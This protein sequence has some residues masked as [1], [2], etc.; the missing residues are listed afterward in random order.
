LD[1]E[2]KDQDIIINT[3][4]V[5]I[6][7]F[8]SGIYAK[9][10]TSEQISELRAR[11]GNLLPNLSLGSG[12]GEDAKQIMSGLELIRK[13]FESVANGSENDVRL[14]LAEDYAGLFL[15]VRGKVPH[16][17]ES[18]YE[19]GRKIMAHP[20]REVRKIYEEAG[21]SAN[22]SFTEPEDHI[23][24]EL[25]FMAFLAKKTSESIRNEDDDSLR[26]LLHSQK[27]FHEKH[28]MSWLPRMCSDV[29]EIGRTDFYKGAALVTRGF[30]DMDR[31]ILENLTQ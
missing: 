17:S 18:A 25:S 28:L 8:L 20:F 1:S 23:A 24:T 4:R 16:P 21:L 6:Y 2:R 14:D 31:T 12:D 10:L 27:E 15:G 29:L 11:R 5:S 30:L 22:K 3:N 9:E 26:R 19:G 7:S 13:Y